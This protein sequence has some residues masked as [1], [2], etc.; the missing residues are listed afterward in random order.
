M[1]TNISSIWALILVG[2]K[3]SNPKAAVEIPDLGSCCKIGQV[4]GSISGCTISL[5]SWAVI[6]KPRSHC[7]TVWGTRV[8]KLLVW[9][10]VF[11]V[12]TTIQGKTMVKPFSG[13][14]AQR[15]YNSCNHCPWARPAQVAWSGCSK[16]V[17]LQVLQNSGSQM[18]MLRVKTMS[19][20]GELAGISPRIE[21]IFPK[22]TSKR[23]LKG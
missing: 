9:A 17:G 5:G 22:E 13:Q 2:H 10:T 11:S 16:T 20:W 6:K 12:F 19:V 1:S 8:G 18:F 3:Y 23:Y 14:N 4:H 21:Q 7:K 15:L